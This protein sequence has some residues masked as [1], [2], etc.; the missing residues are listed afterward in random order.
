M[1]PCWA[2]FA[3]HSLEISAQRGRS[4]AA[5]LA[6]PARL[7]SFAHLYV[8]AVVSWPWD[9]LAY[10]SGPAML[11]SVPLFSQPAWLISVPPSRVSDRNK[12]FFVSSVTPST[13]RGASEITPALGHSKTH[14]AS[15]TAV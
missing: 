9:A 15:C 2:A 1:W 13:D 7:G 10:L 8:G 4:N 3:V 11:G 12:A 14:C 6:G 5:L